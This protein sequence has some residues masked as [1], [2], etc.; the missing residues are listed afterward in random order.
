MVIQVTD[1]NFSE[2]VMHSEKPVFVDFYADW[3]GPCKIMSPVVEALSETY[4]E[5]MKFCKCNVD[6]SQEAA[7]QFGIMSIP[8]MLIF[9]NGEASAPIVGSQPKQ[10]LEEEIAKYC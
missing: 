5:K 3:C 4:G 9:R 6:E 1:M 10:K 8:T 2:E 7:Q